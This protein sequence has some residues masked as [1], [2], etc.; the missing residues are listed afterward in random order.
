MDSPFWCIK[1]KDKKGITTQS[2]KKGKNYASRE[3]DRRDLFCRH[4]HNRTSILLY[5]IE[6][7]H[8][9][10]LASQ[11]QRIERQQNISQIPWRHQK[12]TNT[13]YE[14]DK[15]FLAKQCNCLVD[16]LFVII[17]LRTNASDVMI[18]II[19]LEQKIMQIKSSYLKFHCNICHVG[20]YHTSNTTI[21]P[22]TRYNSLCTH[23]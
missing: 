13:I 22:R 17:L 14:V 16:F 4:E 8:V 11:M 3:Y 15:T 20:I 1:R 2:C 9:I 6:R 18:Y 10:N 23:V 21:D 19:S 7:T 12:V 5:A